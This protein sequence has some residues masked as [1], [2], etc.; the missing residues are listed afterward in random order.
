MKKKLLA[1]VLSMALAIEPAVFCQAEAF[2]SDEQVTQ[3]YEEPEETE[4]LQTEPQESQKDAEVPGTGELTENSEITETPELAENP[5]ETIIPDAGQDDPSA[6]DAALADGN[7][8]TE[9][10]TDGF[11][12][13]GGSEE[14]DGFQSEN[15]LD[16]F[17]GEDSSDE[18]AAFDGAET[19]TY[20]VSDTISAVLEDGVLTVSG[21]GAMADYSKE[22]DAPWYTERTQIKKIVIS[23]GITRVGKENFVSCYYAE[24]VSF[25]QG[26]LTIG[27]AAFYDC[28]GIRSVVLPD[29]LVEIE[30]GAFANCSGISEVSLGNGV[31]KLDDYAF[32]CASLKTVHIPASVTWIDPLAFFKN[33]S[34]ESIDVDAANGSY[35]SNNGVLFTKDMN[36]LCC[37]PLGR[38]ES[39]YAVPEGVKKIASSAFLNCRTIRQV[40]FPGTL[41]EIGDWALNNTPLESV[42][43]PDSVTTIGYGILQDCTNLT[44]V[45]I[46]NGATEVTYRM[47]E[48]CSKLSQ[49][50]LGNNIKIIDN[51]A[52]WNCTALTDIALPEGLEE[53]GGAAFG[54][55]TGL[56]SV[57]IPKSVKKIDSSA[58]YYCTNVDLN[59]PSHLTQLEDG[60]YQVVSSLYYSGNYHYDDA[61]QV[62]E[63][64]NQERAKVGLSALAM[65]ESLLESAMQRAAETCLDFSHTRPSGLSCFT[66]NAK[67][68]GEN[69]AAGSST[70]SAVMENWMNSPGHKANILTSDYKS[71]GIGC[72]EQGGMKFWVQL[73]GTETPDS[74]A[75]PADRSVKAK[76]DI[77]PENYKDHVALY[78]SDGGT[79]TMQK[80]KT[81]TLKVRI[82]N[83]GW[84]Y[85]S[86][87]P[88][89]D[90]FQW[91]SSDP[92][93]ASVD[94]NGKVTGL[95][96]GNAQ[97]T[98]VGGGFTLTVKVFVKEAQTTPTPG[99][100]GTATVTP[101]PKPGSNTPTV[102]NPTSIALN[103]KTLK[104]TKGKTATL[105][106]TI[107]PSGSS[108][109]VKWT[110]S[111]KSVATVDKNGKITAKKKGTAV[112]TATTVNGKKATCKVTVTEIPATKLKLNVKSLSAYSGYKFTIKTTLTPKKSTDKI[113][114]KSSNAKVAS[115]SSKGVVT[116]KKKG[117][118]TI[119]AVTTSGKKATVKINV[120]KKKKVTKK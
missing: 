90:S 72:F 114:W 11:I 52:F 82:T 61:Y 64:V 116:L 31:Q 1:A 96:A 97:I 50:T 92:T 41:T 43:I 5:E 8:L 57:T 47:F 67:A 78:W 49:V 35:V 95:A 63:I 81:R 118:A 86:S 40:T 101:T 103:K 38:Q 45:V 3:D 53:I 73:F 79:A 58:F 18:L 22:S 109:T 70:A 99:K 119:T 10:P 4:I 24:E 33:S 108:T 80:G 15:E 87:L 56:T 93:V 110:S 60:S 28:S 112:I 44:S 36:T 94:A 14:Q 74:F 26:L 102:K 71:I 9:S 105:K 115:V 84:T 100:P 29:S 32:Q 6:N 98:A 21:S 111:K 37:Y 7:G 77:I 106:A 13:D 68:S 19:K 55:C 69:I 65:D 104:L 85:V 113:T 51:R 88:D 107:K 89:M 83:P 25:P 46:G 117:K 20:T 27:D 23:Q 12:L 42:V 39:S 34:L 59:V 2:F 54:Y 30:S 62:L 91:S 17:V 75:K 16:G 120:W 66:V 76:I 48:N